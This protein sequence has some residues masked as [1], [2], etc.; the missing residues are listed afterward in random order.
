[1]TCVIDLNDKYN[2]KPAAG[3]TCSNGGNFENYMIECMTFSLSLQ[4]QIGPH[5]L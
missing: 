1:M 3:S 5:S 4:F 2:P